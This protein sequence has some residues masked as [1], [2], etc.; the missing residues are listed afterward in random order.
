M[1]QR[2]EQ[3]LLTNLNLKK[4]QV[5]NQSH[6]HQG[7]AG[8]DGSGETHFDIVVLKSDFAG[9]SRVST[10]RQINKILE[11]EFTKNGLHALSIKIEQ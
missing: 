10:H 6:L 4:F 1:K 2:I 8:D 9:Q 3:K 5:I 11:D 7:H